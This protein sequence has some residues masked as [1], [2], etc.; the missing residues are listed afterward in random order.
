M[1][2][3]V[4]FFIS[5]TAYNTSYGKT[6]QC[7]GVN[8]TSLQINSELLHFLMAPDALWSSKYFTNYFKD[9]RQMGETCD[10]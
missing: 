5:Y 7:G 6:C 8:E 3:S 9:Y 10:I 4:S 2:K 1:E